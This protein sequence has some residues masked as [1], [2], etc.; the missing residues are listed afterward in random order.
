MTP[1]YPVPG[2]HLR[3]RA[4]PRGL[5]QHTTH[6]WWTRRMNT[7][8]Y[9]ATMR[10]RA[11]RLQRSTPAEDEAEWV[12][13]DT[14]PPQQQTAMTPDLSLKLSSLSQGFKDKKH[15]YQGC[16]LTSHR[17]GRPPSR[18]SPEVALT[19]ASH[20][21]QQKLGWTQGVGAGFSWP[22]WTKSLSL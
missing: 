20:K 11:C 3:P 7:S 15:L 19:D 18:E 10:T 5:I 13:E 4:Q 1:H 17:V 8:S 22:S 16:H 9:L 14:S 2:E 6:P 12:L 21:G